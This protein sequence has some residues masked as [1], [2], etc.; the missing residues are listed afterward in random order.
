MNKR[1]RFVAVVA[2]VAAG[3]VAVAGTAAT[4]VSAAPAG[5][6]DVVYDAI[7]SPLPSNSDS[8]SFANY[9]SEWGDHISLDGGATELASMTVALSS[10]ACEQ[11]RYSDGSCVTSEDATFEHPLTVRLYEVN[12][13][14]LSVPGDLI[15]EVTQ[16]TEIPFRPSSDPACADGKWESDDLGCVN[17]LLFEVEFDLGGVEVP[18]EVIA[19]VTYNTRN[20]GYE[21]T[22]EDGPY[23]ALN[24]GITYTAPTVGDNVDP[25]SVYA[26]GSFFGGNTFDLDTGWDTADGQITPSIRLNRTLGK[27]D[28]QR[29]GYADYGFRNQGLCI[30]SIVSNR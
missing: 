16:V 10:W 28:C 4:H 21:P 23:N 26:S 15:T 1:H 29:G 9:F 30:A 7:D 8:Y 24:V 20:N 27:D 22:G 3:A 6:A 12:E 11:G 18:D 17:G 5:T 14:D 13:S 19:S 25:D 2:A